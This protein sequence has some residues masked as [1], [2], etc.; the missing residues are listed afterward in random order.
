MV[1]IHMLIGEFA[2]ATGLS[3]DTINFY[4]R[5][6]LLAPETNGKSGRN[7][8]RRFCEADI[9]TA[10]FIRFSQSIGMSLNEIAAINA[11]RLQ[12]TVTP[13]RSVEI[14]SDQLAQIEQKQAEFQAMAHYLRVK[15]GWVNGGKKGP[16]PVLASSIPPASVARTTDDYTA[17]APPAF[18]R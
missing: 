5:R 14:M 8:Y 10:R 2:R 7:P 11:E 15:I 3:V 17:Q 1:E 6:G 9:V 12:G 18:V 4:I 13:A 16:A